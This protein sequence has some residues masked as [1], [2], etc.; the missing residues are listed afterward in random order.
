MGHFGDAHGDAGDAVGFFTCLLALPQLPAGYHPGNFFILYLGVYA[1]LDP[2]VT[3][4][5]SGRQAHGATAPRAPP[6]V[7]PANDAH[8][9]NLIFYPPQSMTSGETTRYTLASQSG[10]PLYRTPEMIDYRYVRDHE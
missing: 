7:K 1:T 9:C 10:K 4:N 5:F 3:L 2:F 6:G 8:R